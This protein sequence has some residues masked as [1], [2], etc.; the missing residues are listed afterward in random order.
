MKDSKESQN[1]RDKHEL[2]AEYENQLYKY[3]NEI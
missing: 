2:K 1:F 3:Q